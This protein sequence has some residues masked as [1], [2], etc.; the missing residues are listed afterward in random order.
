MFEQIRLSELRVSSGV[1]VCTAAVVGL[2]VW[3]VVW[4]LHHS[5]HNPTLAHDSRSHPATNTHRTSEK[6]R[7]IALG[8]FASDPTYNYET[9]LREVV[10]HGATDVMIAVSWYQK[11]IR[12]VEIAPW[13][14]RSPSLATYR[15]TLRQAR[16]LGLRVAVMPMVQL[17]HRKP[18]EWRG[19]LAPT[20]GP[21]PWFAS[22]SR[23]LLSL[24]RIAEQEHVFRFAVGSELASL[25]PY[26]AAWKQLIRKLR[27]HYSGRLFYSANWD[28]HNVLDFA[29]YLDEMAVTAY[30]P[31]SA[32]ESWPTGLVLL[33][34]WE[35]FFRK[36]MLQQHRWQRPVFLSE[37]GY[38]SLSSAARLPWDETVSS[39]PNPA[40][41]A[42]LWRYF[43]KAYRVQ[44]RNLL[45]FYAWNWFGFGGPSD[46]SHSLRGKPA[47]RVLQRCLQP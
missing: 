43:C 3:G 28:H 37:V 6:I 45:G 33:D 21:I 1:L 36:H 26:T 38:P 41:Q 32:E 47:A 46:T 11:D 42:H 10:A 34:Q 16:T 39:T 27:Q 31:M 12:G 29:P 20:G 18:H 22:Y 17:Q 44:G 2:M 24:I 13:P 4:F 35:S 15:R 19:Q 9:L 14:G 5:I 40:L 25:E 30:I 23:Y 8:L 7:G